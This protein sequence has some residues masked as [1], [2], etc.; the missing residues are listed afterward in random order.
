MRILFITPWYPNEKNTVSG[1]YV[2]ELAKAV[3]KF[4]SVCVFHSYPDS[5]V[6]HYTITDTFEDEIR[7]V[8]VKC[9]A[10][11]I[12]I[13]SHASLYYR[14]YYEFCKLIQDFKPDII[15]AHVYKAGIA[16]SIAGKKF[17]IPVIIT[18]HAEIIDRFQKRRG[19]CVLNFFK[20]R[21][22][23]F[24]YN[25][26]DCVI[27]VSE[28]LKSYLIQNKIRKKI[29][30]VPNIVNTGLFSPSDGTM[31]NLQKNILFV[32]GLTPVKGLLFLFDAI[33]SLKNKRDDFILNIIGDGLMR[34]EYESYVKSAGIAN[35]VL[36][37]GAKTKELTS[38]FMKRCDFL[39]LP[40]IYETFG[41]VLIEA[42][43]CGKPV[44]STNS[45]GQKEFINER[46]GVL[47]PPGDSKSLMDAIDFML[48]NSRYYSPDIISHDITE[49]FSYS[50]IGD[51]MRKIY[52]SY[53]RDTK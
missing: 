23:R 46:N 28:S 10:T 40:S 36:F 44:I 48:D 45:G 7:V 42:M 15:H 26:A 4:C 2:L 19:Q 20:V 38:D 6:S 29:I 37:H 5:S 39:V 22:A 31:N 3:S 51:Q 9:P 21:M 47:I 16:G 52:S 53:I 34:S 11:V 41:I 14:S 13:V 1:T 49:R 24:A 8:R 33:A 32:G 30:V 27:A 17:H 50:S 25:G 12:P 18:E 35:K 43:A